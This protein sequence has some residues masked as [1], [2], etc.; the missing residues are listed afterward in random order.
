MIAQGANESKLR[1]IEVTLGEIDAV[2]NRSAWYQKR[3][4]NRLWIASL[5]LTDAAFAACSAYITYMLL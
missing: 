4:T 3:Q 5:V 1:R 2:P